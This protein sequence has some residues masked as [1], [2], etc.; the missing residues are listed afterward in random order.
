M[1]AATAVPPD[2]VEYLAAVRAALADLPP[3][4]RDDLLAEVEPSLVEASIDSAGSIAARLGPPEVFAAELRSAAGFHDAAVEPERTPRLRDAGVAALRRI[5]A[6]PGVAATRGIAYDLAPIWW[7]ARAYVL[8]VSLVALG[9]DSFS[10]SYPFVPVVGTALTGLGVVALAMAAS[11]AI[12]LYGRRHGDRYRRISRVANL[13]LAVAAIPV[14]AHLTDL[15]HG[16]VHLH[17]PVVAQAPP[18]GLVYDGT[19]VDNIYP[20]S[21]EGRLLH[22]VLLYDGAG[23]PIDIRAGAVDPGRRVLRTTTNRGIFN[24]FPIRYYEPGTRR[25]ARP[26]AGPPVRP[27][28]IETP[29]LVTTARRR[30]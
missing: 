3:G 17:Q 20:Y 26:D 23:R 24:S 5:G 22:D 6:H 9:E 14:V 16:V 25:V 19:P 1:T 10:P 18:P 30:R 27:P 15:R 11:V 7:L 12:G 2:V 21:R 8:V 4:E 29:P 28:R 13:T